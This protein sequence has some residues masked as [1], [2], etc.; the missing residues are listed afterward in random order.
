MRH[1]F[2]RVFVVLLAAATV[3]F[4]AFVVAQITS[5]P[6][7]TSP[8]SN[9]VVM[10]PII[11]LLLDD[12]AGV[13]DDS[14]SVTI[15]NVDTSL[16]VLSNDNNLIG[17]TLDSFGG[18]AIAN[19]TDNLIGATYTT[20]S[21]AQV[22]L[23][24]S[25]L[26]TYDATGIVSATSGTD[27]IFY[28]VDN[29]GTID[30][31]E[32]TV[33]YGEAPVANNALAFDVLSND[34][35]SVTDVMGLLSN[36]VLGSPAGN[37]VSFG[38]GSLGGAVTDN[39][40]GDT[41]SIAGGE[42]TVNADGSFALVDETTVVGLEPGPITFSYRLQ[43][44][45][46]FS[47]AE[48]L[49][50]VMTE[51][52][53]NADS[54]TFDVAANQT[55]PST[56]FVDNGNGVD[57]L[58]SP[59]ATITSFGGGS[60]GG[61][62]TDNMPGAN[63]SLAGG[64]LTINNN[65]TWA[66]IGQPFTPGV[67]TIN[68]RLTN[69]ANTS[70]ATVSFIITEQPVASDD[71]YEIQA[72]ID[73]TIIAAN[74]LFTNNGNGADTLGF[75]AS[76]LTSFGGGDLGGS[77]TS[78]LAGASVSLAGGTLQVTADG[79]FSL[80]GQPFTE[81]VYTFNYRISNSTGTSDATATL[82]VSN[83]PI[84]KDDSFTFS[85]T[86]D[87]TTPDSLYLDNGSGADTVSGAT[88]TS[89]GGGSLGGLITD[90]AGDSSVSFA[91]G[92]L[93]IN[94]DGTWT[95][96]GQPF[97]GGV[98]TV[99]YRL[100]NAGGTSDATITFNITSPPSANNDGPVAASVPGSDFHSALNMPNVVV[101]ADSDDLDQNDSLGNPAATIAS[102]GAI[103]INNGAGVLGSV[104]GSVTDNLAGS[105]VNLGMTGSLTVNADGSYTLIPPTDYT[106]LLTFQY[107]L[108][109]T[110]GS[111][112]AT[113]TLA[114]GAR[115]QCVSDSIYTSS[116]NV[117]IS[118]ASN[119]VLAN[120][121][122]DVISVFNVQGNTANV[123]SATAGNATGSSSSTNLVLLNANGSFDHSP[124]AGLVG[125]NTFSYNVA[126]GFGAAVTP[127]TVT[128]TTSEVSGASPWFIDESTSSTGNLGTFD[129]PFTS[130]VSFNTQNAGGTNQP[131]SD[132]VVYL[133]PDGAYNEADGVNL[134]AG[135]ELIGGT[136]QFDSVYT[137]VAGG[138]AALNTAYTMFAS[139]A[140]G[141]VSTIASTGGN[142]I[143]LAQSNTV[144]GVNIVNTPNGFGLNGTAVGTPVI[145]NV[146]ITG[147]G[148]AIRISTSGNLGSVVLNEVSSSSSP[149]EN[150]L[151]TNSIGNLVISSGGSGL[152]GSASGSSAIRI[153]GGSAGVTYPGSVSKTT[154]GSLVIIESMTGGTK[155]LSG[156]L[157]SA[158]SAT[159][160]LVQNNTG[161]TVNFSGA[162]KTISAGTNAAITL[163]NNT[164]AAVNFTGGGLDIDTTSG[165]GFNA[166][167]GGAVTVQG[168]NNS[169][170]STSGAGV[171]IDGTT[172]GSAGM[173][174]QSVNAGD[175]ANNAIRLNNT[176]SVGVLSISGTGTTDG[177]G[178][179]IGNRTGSDA[180]ITEGSAIY[181]NNTS[182]VSFS[183]MTLSGV[184]DNHAIIGNTVNDLSLINVDVTGNSGDN[185]TVDEGGV[186]LN[187]ITGTLNVS[188]GTYGGSVGDNFTVNNSS[189]T[190][191]A[192]FSGVT[193]NANNEITG[194]NGLHVISSGTST[195]NL[196]V[197]GSTFVGSR[198]DMIL[199]LM[200]GSGGGTVN[201]GSTSANSF[202]QNQ[203]P[204]ALGGDDAIH[205]E[206]TGTGAINTT[207]S[208]N[209]IAAGTFTFE[210]DGISVQ[211][212][213]S[214]T[215]THRAT[216]TGNTIGTLN[217]NGSAFDPLDNQGDAGIEIIGS[218]VSEMIA[219]V[220][221]N[222]VYDYNASGIEASFNTDDG[223]FDITITNN[224]V[225]DGLGSTGFDAAIAIFGDDDV[226]ACVQIDNNSLDDPTNEEIDVDIFDTPYRDPGLTIL[227]DAGLEAHLS[228]TNT[229]AAV[230]VFTDG[231]SG[232]GACIQP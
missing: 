223:E 2:Q 187:N 28:A 215:G 225:S 14:L 55:N 161:G 152:S 73:E 111:D 34:T 140:E 42:L 168:G 221:N 70:D 100:T 51:P 63:I 94:G 72:T 79:G 195:T 1:S 154:L 33:T 230:S 162:M 91:G 194:E 11:Y 129:N 150:I 177:S 16:N 119:G 134:L 164:G 181:L 214:F 149:T 104:S 121:T 32:I 52:T 57:D 155:T 31:G 118:V 9:P 166:S 179:A 174:F 125:A 159:G 37:V 146:S 148:G 98:Y 226:A 200:G 99:D 110:E 203:S 182:G 74:G 21:G 130:I 192:N 17:A 18:P 163:A 44:D 108:T 8:P 126:N 228:A 138:G 135:Q 107:R 185:A 157:N 58:G 224:T 83:L 173:T 29:V 71:S 117:P 85:S 46:G 170:T 216:I 127:C 48:Q 165:T 211:N 75:P 204:D 209:T 176:G 25:G 205:I 60:A 53:A 27:T 207:I 30:T 76:T 12:M 66:L 167:G 145:S 191:T 54:F 86:S 49:I 68:Y 229:A 227:T 169:V 81:G 116:V 112:D 178:G 232:G 80:T 144:N 103:A 128:V 5:P 188:G 89:F 220:D 131:N 6:T 35:L 217:T 120:D 64:T 101:N 142:G 199:A 156:I 7:P 59:A 106:G 147:A 67:Y 23:E 136:V 196:N 172:I 175:G 13:N 102:F 97:A 158:S 213:S 143:D 4:S 114:V 105:T 20:A 40:A 87:Q 50:T 43:N 113:V 10:A 141:T 222:N 88:I 56:L 210:G 212:L 69:L 47:D 193:F 124:A 19:V 84:A 219:L 137:A 96:T 184:Y 115:A 95:L 26:L 123:G 171:N 78:N 198:R 190:V 139:S 61:S 189:G 62:V 231:V 39:S 3:F 132:D 15:G 38:D 208:N 183:N 202:T 160:I 201:I 77:V 109:N 151:L 218:G 92:S 93:T 180:S 206:A 186:E 45:F 197:N 133:D 122:G 90:N 153:T 22:T 41:V 65:G 24:S 36:D 82:T